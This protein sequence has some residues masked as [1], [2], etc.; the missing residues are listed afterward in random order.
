M[1]APLPTEPLFWDDPDDEPFESLEAAAR[2]ELVQLWSDLSTARRNAINTSWSIQCGN[3]AHRIVNLSR[4]AGATP[5]E[6]IGVSLLL[7]GVYERL[8]REAGIDYPPIDW[9]RVRNVAQRIADRNS[10]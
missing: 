1:T 5:W 7:D 10:R 8:H 6:E 3:L 2:H 9:G 4:L